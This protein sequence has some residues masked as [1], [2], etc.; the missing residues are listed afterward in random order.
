[1]AELVG[2]IMVDSGQ[3]MI[4]D[5]CYIKDSWKDE[6]FNPDAQEKAP[7]AF[8]YAG[9][10]SA[11]CSADHYGLLDDGFGAAVGSGYGDGR[12]PVYVERDYSGRVVSLHV[13]FEDD[14]NTATCSDCG[15]ELSSSE[16][17]DTVCSSC[18]VE[19]C[20][21]CGEELTEDG[22][23]EGCDYCGRCGRYQRGLNGEQCPACPEEDEDS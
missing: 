20:V 4:C 22:R 7:Y 19:T 17:D 3:V 5:P 21:E 12:Y 10:S 16:Q 23:C 1:M 9:A 2:R 15:E 6:G 11:T 18:S 14:P 13:Y 8:T